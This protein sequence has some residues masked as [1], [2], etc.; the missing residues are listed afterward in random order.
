MQGWSHGAG[1][2]F[3]VSPHFAH[4]PSNV[5]WGFQ[6][7]CLGRAGS[8]LPPQ[9]WGSGQGQKVMCSTKTLTHK[10]MSDCPSLEEKEG[11][12]CRLEGGEG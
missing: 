12:K 10:K 8:C 3:K 11:C 2:D 1:N 5:W 7:S 6:V 4:L 9:L